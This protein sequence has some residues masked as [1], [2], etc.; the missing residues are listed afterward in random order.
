MITLEQFFADKEILEDNDYQ[1]YI[2]LL[3]NCLIT[4]QL[5]KRDNL[6][7]LDSIKQQLLNQE[8][9]HNELID[10]L[11]LLL[12]KRKQKNVLVMGYEF[13]GESSDVS[14]KIYCR[15]INFQ[16]SYLKSTAFN[17]LHSRIGSRCFIDLLLD[18]KGFLQVRNSRSGTIN[19][20]QLFGENGISFVGKIVPKD[21][22][23][24]KDSMLYKEERQAKNLNPMLE[25]PKEILRS[26]FH[27]DFIGK[28]AKYMPKKFRKFYGLCIKMIKNHQRCDYTYIINHY[29][30]LNK[31]FKNYDLKSSSDYYK[32]VIRAIIC[33]YDKVFPLELLGSKYNKQVLFSKISKFIGGTTKDKILITSLLDDIRIKDISWLSTNVTNQAKMNKHDFEKRKKL[34]T[35]FLEWVFKYY[36]SKLV[37]CFWH[38]TEG[39]QTS[40]LFFY[41]HH[42]WKKLSKPFMDRYFE[43][44][45]SEES[46]NQCDSHYSFKSS[47]IIHGKLR[48]LPKSN[49]FRVISIPMKGDTEDKFHYLNFLNNEIKPVREILKD[50][51]RKSDLSNQRCFAIDDITK[52]LSNYRTELIACNGEIPELFFIKFDVKSCY[53]TIPKEKVLSCTEKLLD[54][55][56]YFLYRNLA[57]GSEKNLHFFKQS[58]FITSLNNVEALNFVENGIEKFKNKL[59]VDK[60]KTIIFSRDE[61]MKVIHQQIDDLSI[62]IRGRC[63]GRKNGLFQGFPLSAVFCDIVY[64]QLVE[65]KFRYLLKDKDSLV[66]RLAD[67]FLIFST[68]PRK[69]HQTYK[70]IET[71][72]MDYSMKVNRDKTI[73]KMKARAAKSIVTF[74]GL[75]INTVNLSAVK[76]GDSYGNLNFL[77]RSYKG[78]Y[79]RLF[80]LFSMRLT[81]QMIDVSCEESV[82]ENIFIATKSILNS[83][84]ISS[85]NLRGIDVFDE[86]QFL[87]FCQRMDT[88]VEMKL[89]LLENYNCNYFKFKKEGKA[90]FVKAIFS[91]LLP[92]QTKYRTVISKL[93]FQI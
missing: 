51:R 32:D 1:D 80:W 9:S 2:D 64:D 22:W 34:M 24:T 90:Q 50:L 77:G 45:L 18:H 46:S 43:K 21:S 6:D 76:D 7:I 26:V 37:A 67:D 73:F 68:D 14:S 19:H 78:L 88:F 16:I 48:L 28:S 91:E 31:N 4:D 8:S 75:N 38:V 55:T 35:S 53:D 23:I 79:D 54:K 69:I 87:L 41:R 82:L 15:H 52:K 30:P 40:S 72:F 74:C 85:R 44:Y 29:C 71:G 93:A 42:V 49:D 33:I 10:H 47:K 39:S 11:L 57:I 5:I 56:E 12:L 61:I 27:K 84:K 89:N 62:V 3:K 36:L 92:V 66:L 20:I 58:S 81:N 59:I 63:Y 65:E 70:L 13:G 86:Y 25:T 17:I 83:F 60:I